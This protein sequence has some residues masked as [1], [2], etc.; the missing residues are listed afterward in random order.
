[1]ASLVTSQARTWLGTSLVM[2]TSALELEQVFGSVGGEETA[3]FLVVS[4]VCLVLETVVAV[5]SSETPALEVT[6]PWPLGVQAWASCFRPP[7]VQAGNC[8][9]QQRVRALRCLICDNQWHLSR[10]RPS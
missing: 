8:S 1:M 6:L 2:S 3:S 4:A 5:R 9:C 7:T 10:F